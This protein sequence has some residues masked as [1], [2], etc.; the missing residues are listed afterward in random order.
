MRE[1][2]EIML[3]IK[4]SGVHTSFLWHSSGRFF[5]KVF[6]YCHSSFARISL[7]P[8]LELML[9][10]FFFG[11]FFPSP[12]LCQRYL[13][14][15]ITSGK[16]LGE[17]FSVYPQQSGSPCLLLFPFAFSMQRWCCASGSFYDF[18]P[19]CS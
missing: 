8:L 5:Y 4:E 11:F 14:E 17:A 15:K 7:R 10:F 6:S 1:R 3:Q 9:V 2:I 16:S 19:W 12:S 13:P 18:R